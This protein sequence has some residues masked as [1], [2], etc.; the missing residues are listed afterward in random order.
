MTS[1]NDK[2]LFIP[3]QKDKS[4]IY[5]NLK[6]VHVVSLDYENEKLDNSNP[7]PY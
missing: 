5:H 4:V 6:A 3:N 1:D 7:L 2:L